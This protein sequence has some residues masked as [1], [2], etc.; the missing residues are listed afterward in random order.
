[1]S[2]EPTCKPWSTTTAPTRWRLIA[3]SRRQRQR[4][5][6]PEHATR[7]S[8]LGSRHRLA[9]TA[10]RTASNAV[11]SFTAVHRT[12]AGHHGPPA[13]DRQTTAWILDLRGV[14]DRRTPR[15]REPGHAAVGHHGSH[16]GEAPGHIDAL[17]P[18]PGP[19]QKPPAAGARGPPVLERC[20]DHFTVGIACILPRPSRR[21]RVPP[22]RLITAVNRSN[23]C[24][25]SGDYSAPITLSGSSPT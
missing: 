15:R 4:V 6:A 22:A 10:R 8:A 3:S 12:W 14:N 23:T 7:T 21:R 13:S 18:S 5:G 20:P 24:F 19:A 9:T 1:M 2:A 16:E 17:G 25:C 11:R